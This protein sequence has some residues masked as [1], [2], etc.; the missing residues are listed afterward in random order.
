M[1]RQGTPIR[2]PQRPLFMALKTDPDPVP[3]TA[4]TPKGEPPTRIPSRPLFKAP[5]PLP[6]AVKVETAPSIRRIPGR[7]LV[8]LQP[9]PSMERQTPSLGLITS[10]TP[11]PDPHP[12]APHPR[13]VPSQP[14]FSLGPE[15]PRPVRVEEI[16]Q[17]GHTAPRIPSRRIV[18]RVKPASPHEDNHGYG[19]MW[20]ELR[21]FTP[22]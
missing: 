16:P 11:P 2:I 10:A 13:R 15:L 9:A 1:V 18:G 14:L 5:A 17:T 7:P 19:Q 22:F 4:S 21:P 8:G 3:T 20:S 12:V 6:E